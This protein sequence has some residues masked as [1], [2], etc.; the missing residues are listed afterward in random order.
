VFP[1][2]LVD[3]L[4]QLE[5]GERPVQVRAQ[6]PNLVLIMAPAG[7]DKRQSTVNLSPCESW[8][9]VG[10]GTLRAKD[11]DRGAHDSSEVSEWG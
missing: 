1:Q 11:E 8:P 5:V 9:K 6:R 3:P 7:R 4:I 10:F 2:H